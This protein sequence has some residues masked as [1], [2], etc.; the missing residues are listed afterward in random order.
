MPS[1]WNKSNK[2]HIQTHTRIIARTFRFHWIIH[3]HISTTHLLT[4]RG[5][6][7]FS[8]PIK[9]PR[10]N[11]DDLVFSCCCSSHHGFL[12]KAALMEK[13]GLLQ[14]TRKDDKITE[15]KRTQETLWKLTARWRRTGWFCVDLYNINEW[16]TCQMQQEVTPVKKMFLGWLSS[17]R[18][19]AN[20]HYSHVRLMSSCQSDV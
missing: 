6:L 2:T 16:H 1:V 4:S 5:V 11:L 10:W 9:N 3:I 8:T 17:V 7:L 13:Q 15:W 18:N 14:V 12:T 20:L 19:N